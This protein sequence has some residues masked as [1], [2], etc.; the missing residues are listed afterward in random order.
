MIPPIDP[1]QARWSYGPQVLCGQRWDGGAVRG[2]NTPAGQADA[3]GGGGR[4][5]LTARVTPTRAVT[6]ARRG[7]LECEKNVRAGAGKMKA[8]FKGAKFKLERSERHGAIPEG[9]R[10][11][12]GGTL[13]RRPSRLFLNHA[14]P[15]LAYGAGLDGATA[16]RGM[17][18][19]PM[20]ICCVER[21]LITL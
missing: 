7:L 14:H 19:T 12:L 21:M 4:W 1:F 11:G 13:F 6:L 2:A 16:C 17:R 20:K 10:H 3:F 8:P 18:C 9:D 15:H 5:R